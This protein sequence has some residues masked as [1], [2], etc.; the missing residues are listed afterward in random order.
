ML[1]APRQAPLALL[2]LFLIRVHARLTLAVD[3]LTFGLGAGSRET[4]GKRC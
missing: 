3:C 1:C 2:A 4:Q